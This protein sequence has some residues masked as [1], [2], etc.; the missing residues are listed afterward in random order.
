MENS[1]YYSL[2][3]LL[4]SRLLSKKLKANTFKTVIGYC[5]VMKLGL[6]SREELRLW[7][8]ENKV[9]RYLELRE[10]KLQENDESYKMLS[11][12]HCILRLT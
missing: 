2:D 1:C 10:T 6:T 3:N 11:F 7:V 4:S 12:M 9:L 5:I 8:F